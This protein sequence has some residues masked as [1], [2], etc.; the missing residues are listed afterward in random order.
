MKTE[1]PPQFFRFV[2]GK[3]CHHHG[4][5]EHLLLKKRHAKGALEHGFQSLVII[6]DRLFAGAPSQI[7]MNHVALDRPRPN[8]RDFNHHIVK[9]FRFHSGQRGHLRAALDL[10]HADGVGML[11][12]LECFLVIFRD[13][14]QIE[15][16]SAF[17]AKLECILHHRH[18]P[19]A[20]QIDLHNAEVFAIVL[21]PLRHHATRHER[22]L[23]R[24]ERTQFILANDHS[25]GMLAEMTRQ[26]VD[27]SI[28]SDEYRQARMIFCQTRLLNLR[29]QF[30]GVGKIAV[31][32][33]M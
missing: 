32:K 27:R 5:L 18:H 20:Q 23:Q 25:A 13:V 31:G 11:H 17:T 16:T 22:V 9:A 26:S 14:S 24:H 28:K 21:V 15:R 30:H 8:D 29:F 33:E 4:D 6:C 3:I 7:R 19:E 12:D 10:E 2:A 1:C